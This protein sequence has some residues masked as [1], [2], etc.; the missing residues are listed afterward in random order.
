MLSI[1]GERARLGEAGGDLRSCRNDPRRAEWE[2]AKLDGADFRAVGGEPRWS[3]EIFDGRRLVLVTGAGGS[4]SELTL[5]EP[6]ADP[7]ARATRWQKDELIFEVIGRP[8]RDSTSG[9]ELES[10]VRLEWRGRSFRGCGR[11]LH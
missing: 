7:E 3:L 1:E 8:C 10:E 9:E 2:R 11:A 5:P 6:S 4:R